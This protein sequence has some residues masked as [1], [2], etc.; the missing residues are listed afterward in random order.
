MLPSFLTFSLE[1]I[2][3][4]EDV[5][6]SMIIWKEYPTHDFLILEFK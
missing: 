4:M 1:S 6:V 2:S 3:A 5:L